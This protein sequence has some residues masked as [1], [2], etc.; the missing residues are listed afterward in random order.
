MATTDP[1]RH[2]DVRPWRVAPLDRDELSKL[3]PDIR[4]VPRTD[5]VFVFLYGADRPA[6]GVVMDHNLTLLIDP[7]TDQL[8]GFEIDHFLTEAVFA[9]PAL[10]PLLD[11]PGMPAKQ[12]KEVRK[13]LD[14]ASRRKVAVGSLLEQISRSVAGNGGLNP[15]LP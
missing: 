3:S 10:E 8:L 13:K 5:S 9:Q 12:A 6:V 11:L 1:R 4:Y 7:E 2:A 14:P 15:A